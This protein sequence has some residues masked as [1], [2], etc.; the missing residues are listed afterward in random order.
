MSPDK[1]G[2]DIVCLQMP[3]YCLKYV[4]SPYQLYKYFDIS[5]RTNIE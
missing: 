4:Y 5:V 2:V 1:S 3:V